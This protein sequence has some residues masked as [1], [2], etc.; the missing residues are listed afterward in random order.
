MKLADVKLSPV[1]EALTSRRDL[2]WADEGHD[3]FSTSF[4]IEDRPYQIVSR[5]EHEDSM[6]FCRTD[7]TAA[8]LVTA[9]DLH[10]D[11]FPVLGIVTNGIKERFLGLDGYYFIAKKAADPEHYHSR[12]K[13]YTRIQAWMSAELNLLH[14]IEETPSETIFYLARD[15]ERLAVMTGV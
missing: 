8:G 5:L 12:C 15:A 9:T 11:R 4:N 13:L 7:F 3:V 6:T 14:H 2:D 10:T 1:M